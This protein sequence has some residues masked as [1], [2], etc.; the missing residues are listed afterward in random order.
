MSNHPRNGKNF[1]AA[2]ATM[3]IAFAALASPGADATVYKCQGEQGVIQYQESPCLLGRELRNFDTDPPPLSIVPRDVERAAEA[4]PAAAP[5]PGPAPKAVAKPQT[6]A[7]TMTAAGDA[8]ARKF[9]RQGMTEGEVLAAIGRPDAT[10][11]G[12]GKGQGNGR[13]SYLPAAGDPDTVTTIT[14]AGGAVSEVS[15]KVIRK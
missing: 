6:T 4:P 5:A 15:R 13:W 2:T 9:I 14:F 8:S 10:A 7:A 12:K 1:L 3:A 11:G